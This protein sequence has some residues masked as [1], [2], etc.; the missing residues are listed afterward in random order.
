MLRS[1]A[2]CAT[3]PPPSDSS[4]S[5]SSLSS[6]ST[7]WHRASVIKLAPP[8]APPGQGRAAVCGQPFAPLV[9]PTVGPDCHSAPWF[10]PTELPKLCQQWGAMLA[11]E[12]RALLH[13]PADECEPLSGAV[14]GPHTAHA[15]AAPQSCPRG[16]DCVGLGEPDWESAALMCDL[17]HHQGT[18]GQGAG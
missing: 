2:S 3:S 10:H 9:R 16:V 6:I 15:G 11:L 5:S 1:E 7:A 13:A 18:P 17:A 14:L 12:L 8:P 4:S